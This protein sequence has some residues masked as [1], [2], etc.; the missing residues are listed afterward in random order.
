MS[1]LVQEFLLS[2][3]AELLQLRVND[4][5]IDLPSTAYLPAE[6]NLWAD[7]PTNRQILRELRR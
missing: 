3:E 2:W 6:A 7:S 1:E 5:L 4:P